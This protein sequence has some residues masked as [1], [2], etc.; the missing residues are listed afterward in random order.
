MAVHAIVMAIFAICYKKGKT[1]F[2]IDIT[3]NNVLIQT[4]EKLL[5]R[6]AT[7]SQPLAE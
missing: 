1:I 3:L 2:D 5:D 6:M 7:T 4:F